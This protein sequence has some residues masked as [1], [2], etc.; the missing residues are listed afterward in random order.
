MEKFL[1]TKIETF[2]IESDSL[3][4]KGVKVAGARARKSTLE[5][6]KLLKEFRKVSI[7]ESKK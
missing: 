3:I 5:I 1:I 6:E 7:E 4:E 2:K